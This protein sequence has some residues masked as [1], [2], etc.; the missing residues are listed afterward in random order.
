MQTAYLLSGNLWAAGTIFFGLWLIPMGVC[1]LR[2][3]RMPA[4]L[5]RLLIVGGP[6]YVLSAFTPHL[7][8]G[9]PQLTGL[10]ALPASAGEFWMI[11]CLLIRGVRTPA[12]AAASA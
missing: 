12:P 8:P 4:M 5:G 6:L 3:G 2:S 10:L 11:A 1:V 9:L 7:L